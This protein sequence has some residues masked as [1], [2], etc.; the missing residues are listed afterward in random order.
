MIDS[1]SMIAHETLRRLLAWNTANPRYLRVQI[2]KPKGVDLDV[3][4]NSATTA[5]KQ[6]GSE[7]A[8]SNEIRNQVSKYLTHQGVNH[9]G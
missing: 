4:T 2:N 7:L 9:N 6:I 5:L 1:T 8:Y 3:T